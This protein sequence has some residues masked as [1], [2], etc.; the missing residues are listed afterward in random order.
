MN[1]LLFAAK[2]SRELCHLGRMFLLPVLFTV[3]PMM[4]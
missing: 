3:E 4:N 2:D 1:I